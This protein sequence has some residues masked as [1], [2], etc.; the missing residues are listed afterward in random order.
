LVSLDFFIVPTITFQLLFTF[1]ILSHDR[2]RLVHFAVTVNPTA[3]WTARQ[4][5]Q[6]FPWDHAPRYLL[7][8]RDRAYGLEFSGHS[9]SPD[10]TPES[11]AEGLRFTLHL[12]GTL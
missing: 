7:R 1:V 4:L 11:L 10:C 8:D 6:A 5:P 2:R 3:E 9:R 12:L